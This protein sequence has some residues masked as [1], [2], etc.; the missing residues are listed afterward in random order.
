MWE[1]FW[2]LPRPPTGYTKELSGDRNRHVGHPGPWSWRLWRVCAFPSPSPPSCTEPAPGGAGIRGHPGCTTPGLLA[3]FLASSVALGLGK[4]LGYA[5]YLGRGRRRR[6]ASSTAGSRVT[7]ACRGARIAKLLGE[8][9]PE[10]GDVVIPQS[11]LKVYCFAW[12]N[13]AMSISMFFWGWG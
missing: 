6:G 8:L 11:G 9:K 13:I 1:S 4:G 7:P 12:K 3:P 10:E 2:I 5:W